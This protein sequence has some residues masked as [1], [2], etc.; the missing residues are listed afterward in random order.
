MKPGAER[1]VSVLE[2][3]MRATCSELAPAPGT[4]S[5]LARR[6]LPGPDRD[7]ILVLEAFFA[8]VRAIPDSVSDPGVAMAKLGWW[9][10]ELEQAGSGDAR[11]PLVEALHLTGA[12]ARLRAPVLADWF[13]VIA[14]RIDAPPF[15][16][17]A[18]LRAWLSEVHGAEVLMLAGA[19]PATVSLEPLRDLGARFG[20]LER[21]QAQPPGE[22]RPGWVPLD[23]V[24]RFEAP[25]SGDVPAEEWRVNLRGAV[26]EAA[27]GWHTQGPVP[28]TLAGTEAASISGAYLEGRDALVR[29]QLRRLCDNPSRTRANLGAAV[30]DVVSAWR[31]ARRYTDAVKPLE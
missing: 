7:R 12:M 24:A 13:A 27:L 5:D 10:N 15:S 8:C 29:R 16:D 23:L 4:P 14:S 21:L 30:A 28:P 26:A 17:L 25:D 11:H 22:R 6:F 9:R 2:G 3:P 1:A 18:S 19:D 20:V 31:L